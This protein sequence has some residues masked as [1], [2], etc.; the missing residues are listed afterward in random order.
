MT[1]QI[2]R[3]TGVCTALLTVCSA[4]TVAPAE[5]DR[6]FVMWTADELAEIRERIENES[7]ARQWW[8]MEPANSADRALR[9]L[10]AWQLYDDEQAADKQ[11]QILMG[12]IRSTPPLGGAQWV[13]VVRF[14][15]LYE[16]LTPAERS[17]CER[18]FRRYIDHAIFENALFDPDVFNDERNYSRYDAKFYRRENWLPNI[19]WPRRISANLMAAALADEKLIRRAWSHYGSWQWYFDEYL[20]DSGFYGEEF[21]KIGATPGAMIV[22]CRAVENLG[23]GELGFGYTGRSGATMRGHIRSLV[24]IAYPQVDLHSDRPQYPIV[25]MGDL[26]Q[27]GSSVKESWPTFAF[28]HSLVTGYL[29]D[30]F[31][32]N[33]R[34]RAHGAWGGTRRGNHPQWD[35]YTGFTPKMQ[36]PFWFEAAQARWPGDGYA[37]FLAALREPGEDRYNPSLYFGI[38]PI[39]PA[40]AAAPPAPSW[41]APQRGIVMLRAD[42]SADYWL[43]P[44]PAASMRLA[45]PYAHACHDSFALTGLFAYNRQIYMNRQTTRG[46][47]RSYTRSILSHCAVMADEKEPAFTYDTTIR[48]GFYGDVKFAAASSPA[49]YDGLKAT[50]A[51]F[52]TDAYMFD[53]YNLESTDDSEHKFYWLVHALGESEVGGNWSRPHELGGVLKPFGRA[54]T[55]PT[56]DDWSVTVTQTC[57]LDDVSDARLPK[58]WYDRKVGVKLHMLGEDD[59]SV[60]V[61]STPVA[62]TPEDAPPKSENPRMYEI[63]GTSVIVRREA[64][65]TTFAALHVPFEGGKAKDLSLTR[66]S[67]GDDYIVVAVT[68]E[69]RD[70]IIGVNFTGSRGAVTAEEGGR[71]LSFAGHAFVRIENDAVRAWGDVRSLNVETRGDSTRFYL[72]GRLTPATV[73]NGRLRYGD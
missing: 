72:N 28:Q 49:L 25:T 7:W 29:P 65:A 2:R 39:D 55:L 66:M 8:Q 45:S 30:G 10:L 51:L 27:S 24:R 54:R 21:S 57:A 69:G 62:D 38:E 20:A 50:R 5:V 44:A 68:G 6:P 40:E 11:K 42:E 31:G 60:H 46:Y 52:L 35:G 34:W 9:D 43:S 64:Q 22:Y 58:Q 1:S 19:V 3:F 47:A 37:F 71:K 73:G 32:G 23:L 12:D 16:R 26:R 4:A 14:D 13:N 48:D 33:N 53:A 63:G 36:I 56:N 67:E 70:E 41:I 15:M 61:A 18:V 59:T 17:E